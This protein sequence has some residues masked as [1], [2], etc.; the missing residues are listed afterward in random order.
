V[1]D[2][3][4]R[5]NDFWVLLKA[6]N[7]LTSRATAS[8]SIRALLHGV[9][10]SGVRGLKDQTQNERDYFVKE[11]KGEGAMKKQFSSVIICIH[12]AFAPCY[13]SDP[14]DKL[15]CSLYLNILC[16]VQQFCKERERDKYNRPSRSVFE[17][18]TEQT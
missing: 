13:I 4:E 11:F 2:F 14:Q 5:C 7:F 9:R 8:F 10:S 16:P 3:C 18:N 1:V 15:L 17:C 12:R 6:G